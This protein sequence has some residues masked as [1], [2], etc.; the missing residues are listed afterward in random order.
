MTTAAVF[1]CTG[2]V[3]GHILATVL[4]HDA[5]ASVYTISRRQ[6]KAGE[7]SPK[8]HATVEA[9]SAKWASELSALSPFPSTVFSGLGTTRADAGGIA[10][11]WKIDHDL[12][13]EVAEAAKAGGAKTFVFISSA[14]TRGLLSGSVPYSKMKVGVEDKVKELGFDQA[15]I[16]RPGLILG[17][18]EKSKPGGWFFNSLAHGL[19]SIARVLQ[20]SWAVE[21]EYIAKAAVHAALLADQGKAPSKYWVLEQKD[22]IRLGRDEWKA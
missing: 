4:A 10:N 19:G 20:D 12:N 14:G 8:L 3:G 15:I 5:F 22:I 16:V 1:G 2:L 13:V 6:P 11:Q 17:D 9:D 18:R 21:G 7:S